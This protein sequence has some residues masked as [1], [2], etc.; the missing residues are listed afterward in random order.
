MLWVCC[1]VDTFR[2]CLF[3]LKTI[4]FSSFLRDHS[5][6]TGYLD[7]KQK[8][9]SPTDGSDWT[10]RTH[11]FR[12]NRPQQT[13]HLPVQPN[14]ALAISN[15]DVTGRDK[16]WLDAHNTRRKK[17]HERAGKRYIPL[18]WSAA[19]AAE[20]ETFAKKLL[21]DSCGGLYHGKNFLSFCG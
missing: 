9:S 2:Y 16:E 11:E 10:K 7:N 17:Y 5:G 8:F 4:N 21:R 20:S 15:N 3:V 12:I 1:G 19:L 13:S 18:K 6:Y 14:L